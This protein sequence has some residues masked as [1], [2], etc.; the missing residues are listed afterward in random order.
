MDSSHR[1]CSLVSAFLQTVQE[2]RS[3]TVTQSN[4]GS[5][6]YPP[7]TQKTFR[8][9]TY[10]AHRCK[11]ST[12]TFWT[13]VMFLYCLALSQSLCYQHLGCTGWRGCSSFSNSHQYILL[14]REEGRWNPNSWKE[15]ANKNQTLQFNLR[16]YFKLQGLTTKLYSVIS[17]KHFLNQAIEYFSGKNKAG[18]LHKNAHSSRE[19]LTNL[20]G[21]NTWK[22]VRWLNS[23]QPSF[24]INLRVPI[25][26]LSVNPC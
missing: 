26:C 8:L 1:D 15:S 14:P 25:Y 11:K 16:V 22:E 12:Q 23:C 6:T 3:K 21:L 17:K 18:Y 13:A 24:D 9:E 20:K 2:V 4:S 5:S 19:Q 7:L 10:T